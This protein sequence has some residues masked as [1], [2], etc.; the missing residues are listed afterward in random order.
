MIVKYTFR[1]SIS[2]VYALRIQWIATVYLDIISFISVITM[3]LIHLHCYV[4]LYCVTS[5]VIQ[6]LVQYNIAYI[7]M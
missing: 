2:N 4:Y 7:N 3:S 1:Y 6:Y 5:I